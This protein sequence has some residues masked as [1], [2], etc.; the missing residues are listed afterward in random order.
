MVTYNASSPDTSAPARGRQ[1]KGAY[2]QDEA[3]GLAQV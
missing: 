1:L 2:L 3:L